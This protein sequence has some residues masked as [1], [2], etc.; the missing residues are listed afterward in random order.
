MAD[1]SPIIVWIRRDLR[2]GDHAALFHAASSGRPV[3]PV[4]VLDEV[5][6]ELG[7][8]PK[9]RF[10]LGI[11]A[12]S[13]ALRDIGSRLISRRGRALDIL[14]AI[15]AETGAGAVWWQ[16]AYDPASVD[17]DRAVKSAL[18]SQSLDA[19]SFPGHLLFEPWQVESKSGGFYRV[20]TPYWRAVKDRDPGGA[21]SRITRLRPPA[22]WP[23]SEQPVDWN[24]DR[25]MRRGAAVVKKHVAVGEDAAERRLDTFIRH[26]IADYGMMRDFPGREGTS[27]LSENLAYGEVSARRI[28]AESRFALENGY[29]GA[30]SFMRQLAWRDFAYHLLHHTPHIAVDNWRRDWDEFPWND[31]ESAPEILAWQQGRTGVEFV[32]AAMREIYVTGYMHNRA[33]MIAASYLTKHLLGHWRIGLKWFEDCLIDWDP[34]SNAMGWQWV[35]GSGPDAAPFFRIFNPATQ[36]GKF[37]SDEAYIR[38]WIAECQDDPPDAALS[39]FDAVPENWGLKP[40]DPYP[41]PVV[42]LAAGRERALAAYKTLSSRV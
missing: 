14:R 41:Q 16:R 38:R 24:L 6:E 19:K 28:W 10:G 20:F 17:R 1:S 42:A 31:D 34:A 3:I 15:A 7:A 33:R 4:F 27:R 9:W 11:A 39:F 12:F 22:A 40:T 13:D 25:P 18:N 32:D 2:L 30:E 35:A 8:A 21:Y 36:L 26:H 23:S 5:I 37:D 29:P